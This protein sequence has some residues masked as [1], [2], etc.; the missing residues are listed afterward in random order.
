[1]SILQ[2]IRQQQP[3]VLNLTNQVTIG[4][5]ANGLIALGASPIMSHTA[6]EA[7]EMV[8]IA[9]AVMLNI[10]TLHAA[11][12]DQMRQVWTAAQQHKRP[13]VFDPVGIGAVSY[14]LQVAQTFLTDFQATVIRGNAAEIA[15]LAGDF[16][17]AQGVDARGETTHIIEQTRRVAQRYHTIAI[18][19]GP[20]D[21]ISD[22][23]D[24]WL[25][26]NGAAALAGF[27]GTGDIL[28]AILAAGLGA[29]LT[30]GPQLAELVA[31]MGI[32]GEITQARVGQQAPGSFRMGLFDTLAQLDDATLQTHLKL[33]GVQ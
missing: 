30:N 26:E 15:A 23:Q 33:G 7:D 29:G 21:V 5:V 20:Q 22:G 13:V 1:M 10:G 4:D 18:A 14:R 2:T 6:D 11:Q 24:V 31:V 12:I 25:V 17:L 9:N 3:L 19:T 16:G 8:S 27:S 28:S 32:S